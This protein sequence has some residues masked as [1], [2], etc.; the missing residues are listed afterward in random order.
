MLIPIDAAVTLLNPFFLGQ[1]RLYLLEDP[2]P[3][4][5]VLLIR[6]EALDNPPVAIN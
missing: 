2:R 4:P 3:K 5:V 1:A 6:P